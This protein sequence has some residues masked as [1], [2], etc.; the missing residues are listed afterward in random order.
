MR[1]V[2][3]CTV[4]ISA[5]STGAGMA[6]ASQPNTGGDSPKQVCVLVTND[7]NGS[8]G[9]GICLITPGLAAQR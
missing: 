4:I 6:G 7:P 3:L 2:I 5:V 9:D 1:R 8:G